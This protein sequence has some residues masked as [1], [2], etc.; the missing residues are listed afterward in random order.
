MSVRPSVRTY[1]Y[2]CLYHSTRSFSFPLCRIRTTR[3][4][5]RVF[6]DRVPS[7]ELIEYKY[8]IS[9]AH[10]VSR[11]AVSPFL[12][13]Y[14]FSGVSSS[15]RREI[16]LQRADDDDNNIRVWCG[17]SPGRP[18]SAA[19]HS[20]RCEFVIDEI[21]M[22]QRYRWYLRARLQSS[23][24]CYSYFENVFNRDK[25][26]RRNFADFLR[27]KLNTSREIVF[28]NNHYDLFLFSTNVKRCKY[29]Y[30][31]HNFFFFKNCWILKLM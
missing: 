21:Y 23:S 30:T 29:K 22:T 26:I 20:L 13:F 2:S 8:I 27:F 16:V 6:R 17:V 3:R 10:G 4:L 9:Y 18:P 28:E 25:C 31:E 24:G 19:L 11:A 12:L 14:Y 7:A 1:V 5:R 15:S